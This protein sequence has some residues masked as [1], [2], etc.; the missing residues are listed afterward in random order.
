MSRVLTTYRPAILEQIARAPDIAALGKLRVALCHGLA[1]NEL[2]PDKKTLAKW[3][4]A[5]LQRV[6]ELISTA[7]TAGT[8]T[9]V[10]NETFRW[11]EGDTLAQLHAL[12]RAVAGRL[13]AT[14]GEE[15][16]A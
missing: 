16:A 2:V 6:V 9:F 1:T 14:A 3:E 10:Y 11:Y 13:P 12:T 4:Q 15:K 7:K 8:A 5:L